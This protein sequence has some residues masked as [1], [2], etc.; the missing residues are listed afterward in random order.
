MIPTS[1]EGIREPLDVLAGKIRAFLQ[2]SDDQRISAA[3]LLTEARERVGAGEAGKV[4]WQEWCKLN[5]ERSPRDV[6]RLLAL[7][8]ADDPAAK[9][10]QDR[11][12]ARE[13]MAR[14]RLRTNVS[15]L[16]VD[17]APLEAAAAEEPIAVAIRAVLALSDRDLAR[18]HIWY[19]ENYPE[20]FGRAAVVKENE[21]AIEPSR[22]SPQSP[23][24]DRDLIS[25]FNALQEEV[26]QR[27][28]DWVMRGALHGDEQPEGSAGAF[29]ALYLTTS[30]ETRRKF[31]SR[32]IDTPAPQRVL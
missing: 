26:C 20:T 28:R 8:K 2:K 10:E 22:T 13:G 23:L 24:D 25:A 5:V 4:T 15:P 19:R 7:A 14:S 17:V 29:C 32:L 9:A 1:E 16:R 21:I 27:A 18:F 11:K 6:R 31:R 30:D 3:A 12:A